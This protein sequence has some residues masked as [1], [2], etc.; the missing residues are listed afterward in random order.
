MYS[1]DMASESDRKMEELIVEILEE[2]NK[3]STN[4]SSETSRRMIARAVI[5]KIKKIYFK[6]F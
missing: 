3:F 2:F 5:K 1:G 6:S 4:L